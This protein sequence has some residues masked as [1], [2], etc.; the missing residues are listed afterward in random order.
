MPRPFP[1]EVARWRVDAAMVTSTRVLHALEK[2]AAIKEFPVWKRRKQRLV[3]TSAWS[4]DEHT[5]VNEA[6]RTVGRIRESAQQLDA[7]FLA[8]DSL[9]RGELLGKVDGERLRVAAA[10][11][12]LM[13][14]ERALEST[15]C[16]GAGAAVR[17][18]R[19][20]L[21]LVGGALL[22]TVNGLLSQSAVGR[23]MRDRMVTNAE[24]R[25]AA[26]ELHAR[27]GAQLTLD[28]LADELAL[29]E[30]DAAGLLLA[31]EV[32]GAQA[33][34]RRSTAG[35]RAGDDSV[36][37]IPPQECE[38]FADVG[39]L[40][41]VVE[42]LRATIGE[43]IDRPE[44]A[45]RYQVVHNGV[46]FH[47]PPGTGKTLLSRAIAGEYGLRYIR[48]S[49][50]TIASIYVHEAAANLQ[51]LFDL[52]RKSAPCLLFLDEIDSI[53]SVRSDQPSADH[54]E[55]VTQ[56]MTSLEEYRDVPGLVI[57]AATNDIDHLDP[58]LREGR[59]DSKVLVPLPD[60]P[61]RADI[62]RVVLEQR[63]DAVD[64]ST[65]DVKTLAR[66]TSGRNGAA[67]EMA[68]SRA[69]QRALREDR[70]ITQADLV[71]AM[72]EREGRDRAKLDVVLT[73][74][75]VVLTEDA[76]EQLLD[77]ANVF[78]HPD[79]ADSVGVAA[80]AGVILHGPPG[81]G[82]TTVAKVL[83]NELNASFY[84]VSAADMLSKWAAESEQK[85][86]RLFARARAN[87]PT[88][89]FVDEI[90]GLLRRR[91]S[92]SAMPWEERVVSQFLQELDGL[93]GNTGV[94]LVGATNR[95]D[96]LDPAVVGRRLAP[97]E[98]GLP[99]LDARVRLIELLCASS[100]LATDVDVQMLAAATDGMSGADIKQVRDAAGMRALRR[101]TR[102][103]KAAE[104][105]MADFEA[106]LS[107][108][109]GNSA[110]PGP[111]AP[112]A[113]APRRKSTP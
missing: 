60:Q 31:A 81:T 1:P 61:A 20:G 80:P 85:V 32:L 63:E 91:G 19:R 55:I 86:Q 77:I 18:A 70:Q 58:G 50:A 14:A 108:Y 76:R 47:G 94:L 111:A 78:M 52:A 30:V 46:L 53:A 84:A 22:V 56:L 36:R 72:L 54:R 7:A 40:D 113:R 92:A 89:V 88:V 4:N 79:M 39:G 44:R 49:P 106:A 17:D 12:H 83:A 2:R 37:V 10:Y 75:D 59:F 21:S 23:A 82:K 87:R 27:H 67:L 110:P 35:G 8:L 101:A 11:G 33:P 102:A 68:A 98:I 103:K 6:R 43:I 16:G 24:A 9:S 34:R 62:F 51:R 13:T 93:R 104:I 38:T 90:D 69:A 3:L 95:L 112:K 97:I 107:S 41:D 64:W 66:K 15:D 28:S 71:E 100:K 109:A 105:T 99:G 25:R 48:F 96:I 26:R 5:A 74:G 73:R 57:V 29:Y 45:A 42:L 65:I